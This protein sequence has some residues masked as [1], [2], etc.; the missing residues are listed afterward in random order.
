MLI[1]FGKQIHLND[2]LMSA[3]ANYMD[4][5]IR[6]KVHR[7]CAPCDNDTF[8]ECYCEHDNNF[9]SLARVEFGIEII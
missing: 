6:E 7:L 3:L 8:L 9:Y 1:Q 2:A 5:E 4:S